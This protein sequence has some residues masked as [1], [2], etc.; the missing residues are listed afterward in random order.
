MWADKKQTDKMQGSLFIWGPRNLLCT[1]RGINQMK[2]VH[3]LTTGF[4]WTRHL[5]LSFLL[6][7]INAGHGGTHL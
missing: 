6:K 4:V 7:N 5:S 1:I 2:S 3:T